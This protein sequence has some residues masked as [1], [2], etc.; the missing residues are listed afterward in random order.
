ML[1]N[2]EKLRCIP[3]LMLTALSEKED[4]IKAIKAGADD[5]LAKPYD[6]KDLVVKVKNL[7]YISTFIKR[8]C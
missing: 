2:D 7:S 6:I 3:I 8:W 4:V 5:Y 1:K